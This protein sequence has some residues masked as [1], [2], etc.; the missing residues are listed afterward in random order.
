MLATGTSTLTVNNLRSTL[1]TSPEVAL[2]DRSTPSTVSAPE[3]PDFRRLSF[4]IAL[5]RYMRWLFGV[6]RTSTVTMFSTP[7]MLTGALMK[8]PVVSRLCCALSTRAPCST[9]CLAA[10]NATAL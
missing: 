7:A 10:A 1:A 5:C 6:L 8:W 2:P 3:L 4:V 9:T